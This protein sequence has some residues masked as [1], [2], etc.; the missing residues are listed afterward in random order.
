VQVRAFMK[1]VQEAQ[2]PIAYL[3]SNFRR[4]DGA[5]LIKAYEKDGK[6]ILNFLV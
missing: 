1:E 3:N 2:D 4:I 6:K 5:A